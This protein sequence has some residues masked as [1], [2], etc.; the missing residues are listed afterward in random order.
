MFW[1]L[2]EKKGPDRL[3]LKGFRFDMMA[4]RQLF[5]VGAP[6]MLIP[7]SSTSVFSL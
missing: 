7:S 1:E 5:D 6:A 4:V 3:E 2:F